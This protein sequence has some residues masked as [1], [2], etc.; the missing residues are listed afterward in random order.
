MPA[1]AFLQAFTVLHACVWGVCAHARE[2]LLMCVR[3][4]R[5][6]C[7]LRLVACKTLH[8]LEGPRRAPLPPFVTADQSESMIG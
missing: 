5:C 8:A 4:V 7:I 3:P 1:A 2:S 6:V